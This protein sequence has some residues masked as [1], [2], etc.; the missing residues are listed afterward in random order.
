[1]NYPKVILIKRKILI[2]V[3]SNKGI[4]ITNQHTDSK[5]KKLANVNEMLE[6][7]HVLGLIETLGNVLFAQ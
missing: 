2:Y 1:M 7:L 4:P 3:F 5:F 6:I